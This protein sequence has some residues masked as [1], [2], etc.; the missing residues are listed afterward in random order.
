[1]NKYTEMK[2]RHQKEFNNFPMQ[3]AFNKQQFEEGMKNLG[4]TPE[5]TDKIYKLSGT[6]G[7]YL[8]SDSEKLHRLL[9]KNNKELQDAIDN[10]KTGENFIFDMFNYELANHEYCYTRS[11]ES[12]LDALGYT[13]KNIDNNDNLKNG[14]RK[15]IAYQLKHNN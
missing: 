4:I 9:E 3:F 5:Q 12:T 14:L 2:N 11:T 10:D 7:F 15:A 8:K 1:M 13:Q 6:G